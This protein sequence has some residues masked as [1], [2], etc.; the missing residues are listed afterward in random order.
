MTHILR[1][2]DKI[3]FLNKLKTFSWYFPND[4]TLK[5]A[6][7]PI[8]TPGLIKA[9][10]CVTIN[11]ATDEIITI[12]FISRNCYVISVRN[13]SNQSLLYTGA[14]VMKLKSNL[15]HPAAENLTLH[16]QWNSLNHEEQKIK[17]LVCQSGSKDN[18]VTPGNTPPYCL[19]LRWWQN[20]TKTNKMFQHILIPCSTS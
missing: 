4:G 17:F 2:L 13:I 5:A 20:M 6:G 3:Y 11:A 9:E 7:R 8:P 10:H 1:F 19:I 16:S 14:A 15:H 18:S 12:I